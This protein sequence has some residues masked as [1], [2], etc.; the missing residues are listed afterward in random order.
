M[1]SEVRNWLATLLAE[2][3]R[4]GRTVGAAVTVLFQGG[5]GPGAPYVIPLESALRDQHPGIALDHSYQR[6]LRLLQR[7]RR[8]PGDLEQFAQRA[9]ASVDAF[10]VRKEAVKAAYTAALA[11]R[12]IDEA[13]AA[14]DE[15]YVPGRAADEVAPARAAAD[16]MLRAAAE[17][18]RQLGTDTEPEISELRLDAFDLRLLFAA[19]SSDT[20]VLLVVGIG[21]DDWDQWYAEAL[22]LARA[23][24]ELQDDDFTGYDLA[25]FLSEYF[26]GEETAVQAAARLIE[27][28]RAG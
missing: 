11:Q 8:R 3:H 7:V 13:L 26:P 14:F 28:N 23:E 5:F 4:L 21:H 2:D 10:G 6:Q 17:L 15:S 18:E 16:E 1:S 12:T 22:P 27:P 24:L 19:E 20:A 9:Q 25:A